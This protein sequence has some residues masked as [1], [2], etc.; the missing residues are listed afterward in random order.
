M[1]SLHNDGLLVLDELG[2]IDPREA[3]AAA[4]MLANGTGKA[5]ARRDGLARSAATWRLLFLSSGEVGLADHMREA[6][7]RTRAGQEVRL[8]DLPA[9]AGAGHGLFEMLHGHTD[10]AAFAGALLDAA[11]KYHGTAGH[12]Y[13]RRLVEIDPEQARRA[14]AAMRA[15]FVGEVLPA[16]ADGQAR[17][18]ADRFA[19]IAAGGALAT[20]F[21]LTG[22]PEGETLAA[23]KACFRAWLD[24]RGGAGSAEE[25]EALAAVDH[26]IELHGASRFGVLGDMGEP[27]QRSI[28]NRAGHV[29]QVNGRR[30]YLFQPETFRRDVCAGLDHRRV[31]EALRVRGRLATGDGQHLAMK[32][33]GVGRAYAVWEAGDEI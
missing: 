19:L 16:G 22:W 33:R 9:D 30:Q 20:R 32:V 27:E 23:A 3:G 14:I 1:A 24:R 10:G 4:Y 29:R 8:A 18:V 28:I 5:R 17:R 13:L 25:S 11:R 26:F 2:E 15:D 21:D 31:L 12:A 6:G 7:K